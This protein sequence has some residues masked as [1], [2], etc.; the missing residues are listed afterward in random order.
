MTAPVPRSAPLRPGS[1]RRRRAGRAALLLA[2][3]LGA[4]GP[5]PG[6]RYLGGIGDPIRGAAL[7]APRSFGDTSRWAGEPARAAAAASQLELLTDGFRTS[8]RYAPEVS[9][10][11]VQALEAARAEMRGF[12]GI[13][14]DAPPEPVIQALDR[15]TLALD[16]GSRAQA[17]AALSG[18]FFTAGPLVTLS[19]LSAMP[20]LPRSA[21]AAGQAAA[22]IAR[23]D[24][25]RR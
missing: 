25:P 22:E 17:E 4:C 15:A 6:G 1:A 16:G 21:A 20:R 5:E 18:P 24:R 3:M 23:L 8:P 19:R 12:L 7:Y 11:A 13:A 10:S 14:P 9:P 2:L